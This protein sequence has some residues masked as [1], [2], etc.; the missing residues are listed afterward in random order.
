MNK[1]MS[2][3]I[4]VYEYSG[5]G[6]EVLN[7]SLNQ[8]LQQTFQNFELVVSDHSID[9]EI[10]NVC[11]RWSNYFDLKYYR[12]ENDRGSGAAN[13][14]NCIKNCNGKIIK[15]LC[16]DDWLFS[17]DSLQI[18]YENFTDDVDFMAV[19]Y[20][21]SRDRRNHYNPH[22]PQMNDNLKIVNTIGTPSCVAIRKYDDMP[23]FDKN[24]KYAFDCEFY[25]QYLS[26]YNRVKFINSILIANYIWDSSITANI[27]NELIQ[28][29][30]QYILD[31]YAKTS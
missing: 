7:F 22:F 31:K 14:N 13:F 29:E 5:K 15:L 27:D 23:E 1:L 10:E 30:S 17:K 19:G 26:K 4:P 24:L 3:A 18:I 20:Y 8:I 11:K 9:D 28:K 16:A 2:I 21:H 6:V 25:H 12:N